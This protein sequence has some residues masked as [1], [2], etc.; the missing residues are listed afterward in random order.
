MNMTVG[1]LWGIYIVVVV[2]SYI[3]LWL[4][5]SA[6]QTYYRS[7]SYGT[8]FLFATLL[9]AIAVFIGAAGLDPNQLSSTDKTWLSVLFLIAFL[10]PVFVIMYIVWAGEYASITGEE[11]CM[12]AWCKEPKCKQDKCKDDC[13]TKETIHCDRDTGL[14]HIKKKKVHWG[15]NVTKV[16]YSSNHDI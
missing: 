7:I 6:A 16:I 4:L 10:L 13:Y 15:N 12:P 9:G 3:I 11:N 8:T 5:L 1:I 2:L 14:C